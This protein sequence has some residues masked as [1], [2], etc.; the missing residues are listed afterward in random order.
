MTG[1]IPR[2]TSTRIPAGEAAAYGPVGRSPW[3]DIDW[4]T[5]Q[6]W[7]LVD[8]QPVNVIELGEGPPLV[9]V[10]GLSGCWQNFLENLPAHASEHRVVTF[11]LPGFGASPMPSQTITAISKANA[12][13]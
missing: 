3:M 2:G 5:H 7:V 6:R 9:F 13:S 8:G 10:H 11:D 4:R 12:G 1:T